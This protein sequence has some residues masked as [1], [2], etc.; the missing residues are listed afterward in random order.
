VTNQ[1][2]Y[3]PNKKGKYGNPRF[4]FVL[5]NDLHPE[6]EFFEQL[7]EKSDTLRNGN[8]EILKTPEF[9][10]KNRKTLY[11]IEQGK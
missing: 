11:L 4:N 8:I 6:G 1:N 9:A 7:Q 2:W 10:Y 5:T 3:F